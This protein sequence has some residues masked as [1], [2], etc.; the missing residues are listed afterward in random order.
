MRPATV[1]VGAGPYEISRGNAYSFAT[2]PPALTLMR[3]GNS[4]YFLRRR[5]A[6]SVSPGLGRSVRLVRRRP[7][8]SPQTL[9][10]SPEEWGFRA[11]GS[12][13]SVG[14]AT[15]PSRAGAGSGSGKSM[16]MSLLS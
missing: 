4:K 9:V 11:D 16:V 8:G 13:G 12:L 15:S 7:G 6:G 2:V 14:Y 1:P 3:P 5:T 10:V